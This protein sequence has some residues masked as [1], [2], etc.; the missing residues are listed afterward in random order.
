M[1]IYSILDDIDSAVGL[2]LAGISSIVLNE[3]EKIDNKIDE[4]LKQENIGILVVSKQVYE[5]SKQKIEEIKEKRKT[6]LVVVI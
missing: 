4:V 2:K 5:Q 6:P 3:K 1:I